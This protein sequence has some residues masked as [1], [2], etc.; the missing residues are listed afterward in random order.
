[1][2]E[3]IIKMLLIGAI[4]GGYK[5]LY[6][7]E[8]ASKKKE[9]GQIEWIEGT[10]GWK[11][12]GSKLWTGVSP[13]PVYNVG[14]RTSNPLYP[15]DVS[16]NTRVQG[17]LYINSW[18]IK[19]ESQP[20]LN[21]VLKWDGSAFIPQPEEAGT[22]VYSV[23]LTQDISTTSETFVDMPGMSI[24]FTPTKDKVYVFVSATARITDNYG[25]AQFAQAVMLIRVVNVNTG[26]EVA[27]CGG[28]VTDYDMDPGGGEWLVTSGTAAI[29]GQPVS[30]TPNQ[31]VTFKLQWAVAAVYAVSPWMLRIQPYPIWAGYVG[32]HCV[33][34]I[35]E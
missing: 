9:S 19:V 7:P 1:M 14:I 12:D 16:G 26:Q 20:Q 30:V 2:K 11:E 5:V 3:K 22:K 34:T 21:Y 28:V 6:A 13:L 8:E 35:I 31:Q 23:V 4:I 27:R 18:P 15:L 33:F 10:R 29:C 17:L 32:D 24:T 25:Y